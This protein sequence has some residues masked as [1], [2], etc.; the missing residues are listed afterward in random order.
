MRA[1]WLEDHDEFE[2][3]GAHE[4]NPRY[5]HV[6]DPNEDWDELDDVAVS[7]VDTPA[8]ARS[9]SL[10]VAPVVSA[11]PRLDGADTSHYQVAV[12]P[13]DLH[14][15]KAAGLS[16][17]AHKVSQSTTYL[18]PTWH[19][20]ALDMQLAHFRNT[21]GYHWLSSV[22]DPERQAA[23]LL[24]CMA[25]NAR[26]MGVMG[27]CEEQALT[28][29][30]CLAFYE[31]VERVTKRP[32]AH[33]TGAYVA[34]GTLFSDWRLRESLYGMRPVILA[35]YCSRTRM[36]SLPNVKRLGHQAWQYSS[37]GP[38]PGVSG[39]CDMD[40]VSDPLA[41]DKAC[42]AYTT[43]PLPPIESLKPTPPPPHL[44]DDPMPAFTHSDV[45]HH[46]HPPRWTFWWLTDGGTKRHMTGLELDGIR[47]GQATRDA[48]PALTMAEIDTIPDYCAPLTELPPTE[49]LYGNGTW[50]ITNGSGTFSL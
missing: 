12:A 33:Y 49:V 42:H 11:P 29:E 2:G 1:Y 30:R 39:R 14:A 26:V 19:K 28:A 38:V 13:M 10:Q 47:G 35:A 15:A 34:S 25:D 41:F 22:T 40:E 45:D 44:E 23:W 17:W 3:V 46:G 9:R 50:T 37:S 36:E 27:D 31:A 21:L 48:A 5:A 24:K 18:D 20:V 32:C 6:D 7:P 16:W 8:L 4:L 43:T